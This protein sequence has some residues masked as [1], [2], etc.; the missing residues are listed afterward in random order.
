MSKYLTY[1]DQSLSKVEEVKVYYTTVSKNNIGVYI[2]LLD[3]KYRS[4]N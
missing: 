3:K 2:D 1:I 4:E